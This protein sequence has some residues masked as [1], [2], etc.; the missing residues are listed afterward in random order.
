MWISTTNPADPVAVRQSH[1]PGKVELRIGRERPGQ[2][3]YARLS[4]SEARRVA[5]ALLA[6]AE[7]A[8]DQKAN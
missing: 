5:Y 4:P 1:R 3:R 8:L 6:A 2:T 7:E